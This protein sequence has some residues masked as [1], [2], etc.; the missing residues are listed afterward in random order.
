MRAVTPH[1]PASRFYVMPLL[2][3]ALCAISAWTAS[4]R[5][6]RGTYLVSAR[7]S[8]MP[9]HPSSG[10][11]MPSMVGLGLN[12][13]CQQ[14]LI[15][16]LKRRKS[17]LRL[18]IPFRWKVRGYGGC[19]GA[20]KLAAAALPAPSAAFSVSYPCPGMPSGLASSPRAPAAP[21]PSGP[22]SRPTAWSYFSK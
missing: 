20:V 11:L 1:M 21:Q 12:V 4:R 22:P 2:G 10:R 13:R 8:R 19:A 15:G 7:A 17:I 6:R 14:C 9:A 16:V 3:I 18:S 5:T